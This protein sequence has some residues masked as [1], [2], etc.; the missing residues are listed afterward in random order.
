[1]EN[2]KIGKF[3]KEIRN[4]NNL[5]QKEF[6]DILG[7]TY[8]AV[9]KWENGKNIPDIAIIKE[10]S[11]NF[12]VDIEEILDGKSKSRTKKPKNI[13]IILITLIFIIIL[14][15]IYHFTYNDSFQFKTLTSNCN[16]FTVT[17]SV[18]YNNNKS[19]I[20]IS[21][22]DYCESDTTIYNSINCSL[23][24]EYGNTETKISSCPLGQKVTLSNYLKDVKINVDDY[25]ASCK[26]LSSSSL[27]LEI[28]AITEENKTIY[29]KVPIV[30]EDNCLN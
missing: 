14:F 6:A 27:Y 17:G 29:Y 12:A 23:Y 9:S 7:V 22:I 21:N 16:D 8:Q 4:K 26:E 13:I 24:E 2:E 10:I 5:T 3:I 25:S 1:M 11:K 30:L 20:Y 28:S 15:L 19:S 18:A